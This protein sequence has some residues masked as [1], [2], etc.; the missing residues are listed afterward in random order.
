MGWSSAIKRNGVLRHT[1]AGMNLK[2]IKLKK[3]VPKDYRLYNC[4]YMKIWNMQNYRDKKH[5]SA[6]QGL[7]VK[8]GWL[9]RGKREFGGTLLYLSC[10][11]S[12]MTLCGCQNSKLFTKKSDLY[13][14]QIT[15]QKKLT[16]EKE[17]KTAW[18]QLEDSVYSCTAR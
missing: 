10:A 17:N 2:C 15:S 6:Y 7:T 11:N 3:S 5:I 14:M 8:D 13:C 18:F 16:K 12:Y 1:I 4:I 9:K